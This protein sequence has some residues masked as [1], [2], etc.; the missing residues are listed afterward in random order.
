MSTESWLFGYGM[1]SAYCLAASLMEH[2]A[3]F[4][5]WAAVDPA[6]FQAVQTAQGHGSGVVHV[7]PQGAL[8]ALV[9]VL[10]AVAPDGIPV[11]VLWATLAA[12]AVWWSGFAL[13]LPIQLRL[14]ETADPAAIERLLRTNGIRI[15]ATAAQF[16]FVA[17]AV[18]N[19]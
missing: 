9:I 15:A 14:R 19:A 6:R 8:T 13:Q 10:L 11:W 1:L 2:F 18:A 16:G 3:V 17:V 12:L 7:L 5:G 4:S